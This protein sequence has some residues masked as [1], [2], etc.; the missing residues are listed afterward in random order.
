MPNIYIK[1]RMR[2]MP[3]CC[4]KCVRYIPSV[5]IDAWESPYGYEEEC[6]RPPLCWNNNVTRN[7][8]GIQVTKQR[9]AW[10]PL[11]EREEQGR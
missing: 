9:P 1:T 6:T 7:I 10:C 8:E 5:H 4:A 11:V 3:E 2:K